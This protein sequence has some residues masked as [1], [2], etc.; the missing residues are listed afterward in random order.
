MSDTYFELSYSSGLT[1]SKFKKLSSYQQHLINWIRQ[2]EECSL[3]EVALHLCQDEE[4][5]FKTLEPLVKQ[6]ILI[7]IIHEDESF[8]RV[9]FA[10]KRSRKI[11]SKL[12]KS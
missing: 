5:A 7:Q 8:Y 11:P 3:L 1:L 12:K 10:P 4:T 2:K 9:Y 6:G